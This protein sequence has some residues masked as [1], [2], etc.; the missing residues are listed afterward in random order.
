MLRAGAGAL[1]TSVR[2]PPGSWL[3][4]CMADLTLDF[5]TSLSQGSTSLSFQSP[6][7]SLC[8]CPLCHLGLPWP[9]LSF[10]P[11]VAIV[12]IVPLNRSTCPNQRDLFSQDYIEVINL[13]LSQQL[14]LSDSSHILWLNIAD[15]SDNGSVVAP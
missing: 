9:T 14:V 8:K 3:A 10:Y 15:L 4:A 13:K 2:S 12:L 7:V 11:H 1:S 5:H 6:P